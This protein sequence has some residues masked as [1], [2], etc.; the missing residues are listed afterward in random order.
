MNKNLKADIY[1]DKDGD[2]R[3]YPHNE[4]TNNRLQLIETVPIKTLE[5]KEERGFSVGYSSEKHKDLADKYS[6][7]T[8]FNIYPKGIIKHRKGDHFLLGANSD[9]EVC[10]CIVNEKYTAN[11]YFGYGL[12]N[13]VMRE[14]KKQ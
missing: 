4:T 12:Y 13:L 3:I 2:F 11:G 8:R 5:I 7:T 1:K 10:K 9:Y 6:V 14:Y